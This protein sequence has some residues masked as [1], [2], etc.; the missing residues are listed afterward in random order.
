MSTSL[1]RTFTALGQ[2]EPDCVPLFLATGLLGARAMGVSIESYL[3]NG[4][5][6]L[7]GQ[8]RLREKFRSD[9]LSSCYSAAMEL[10]AWGGETIY[11]EDG[12]P[13]CGRPILARPEQIDS[14]RTPSI[15]SAAGLQ[16]SL[17]VL[18]AMKQR[19]G[20]EVVL[21]G[22]AISPFSLPIIQMGFAAYLDLIHEQPERWQTL[23]RVNEEFC[24]AWANAQLEAGVTAIA[25]IDP[26]SSPSN[27][28][29]ELFLS[30]G[31]PVAQR[32]LPRIHGA[33]AAHHASGR[34]LAI[35]EEMVQLGVVGLAV[36]SQED[37]AE[38]KRRAAGRFSLLGNLNGIEMRRWTAQ[39]A[40]AKVKEAIAKAAPGGGFIL[41]D[42]HG[43]IPWQVPDEVLL[44]I[45]AAVDKWGKYPL[46]W[47]PTGKE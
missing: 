17:A 19:L 32:T 37:L 41:T 42:N 25:Y 29:R 47:I 14:L 10:E 38:A 2:R 4:A 43:E 12:P 39:E 27:I 7:E 30:T 5:L 45:R 24:V 26:F 23:M 20:A 33:V 16:R 9:S 18:A 13:V 3:T 21:L 46:D 44:A 36:S 1:E 11:R 6:F 15:E 31:F 28:P 35:F 8:L 22:A 34:T 40:E